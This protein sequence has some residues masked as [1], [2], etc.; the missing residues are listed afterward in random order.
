M[1]QV[2]NANSTHTKNIVETAVAAGNFTTLAAGLKAAH[3]LDTLSGKGPFTVFAP[4]DEAFKKL[5]HGALE[6]LLKDQAKLKAVLTYHVASGH[7][8]AKDLTSTDLKTVEGT[9]VHV[10]VSG[11]KVQINEAHVTKADIEASNGVI[12][13]IDTVLL[14]KHVKLMAE[15]A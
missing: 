7:L 4:T 15:A 10:K 2:K 9:P 11:S 3:L 14:P 6:A 8:L 5:P 13:V 1:E 12:H